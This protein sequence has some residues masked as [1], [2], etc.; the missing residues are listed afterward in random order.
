MAEVILSDVAKEVTFI[1][2]RGDTLTATFQ[3]EFSE[4]S[5]L[6]LTGA[7]AKMTVRGKQQG[8][9]PVLSLSTPSDALSIQGSAIVLNVPNTQMGFSANDGYVWDLQVTHTG[10]I[11]KTYCYG[12]FQLKP[13]VSN[14]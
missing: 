3:F 9:A 12:S 14:A 2:R 13:D 8:L 6:S 5:G 11:V 10:G 4:G 7:S 1:A